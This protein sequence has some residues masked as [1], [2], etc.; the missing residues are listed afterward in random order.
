MQL[1]FT[2]LNVLLHQ[3]ALINVLK[4][5][6]NIQD[7]ITSTTATI[8]EQKK[9][10]L[11]RVSR[12]GHLTTIQ[13]DTST[14]IKEQII[15]K[16]KGSHKT[17]WFSFFF[18]IKMLNMHLENNGFL[19]PGRK[20]SPSAEVVDLKIT[21]K[22]GTISLKM[23]NDYRDISAFYVEGITAGYIMKESHS[24]VNI[25]LFSVNIKDLNKII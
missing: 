14:F 13:E 2:T 8:K 5:L 22:I 24:K 6:S 10:Q 7:N 15:Q 25:Q 12:I 21:A 16:Q 19:I 23:K 3:E 4:F 17:R 18:F 11:Q 9:E 20:K 1:E